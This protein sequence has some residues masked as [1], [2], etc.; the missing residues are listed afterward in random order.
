VGF[1]RDFTKLENQ[2]DEE[3]TTL[4]LVIQ[5][6]QAMVNWLICHINGTDKKLAAFLRTVV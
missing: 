1:I 2:F 5:T 6:N 4:S 3:G